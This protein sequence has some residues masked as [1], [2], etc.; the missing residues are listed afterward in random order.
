MRRR[1]TV[2]SLTHVS[3]IVRAY[4]KCLKDDSLAGEVLECSV[5]EILPLPMPELRN[6]RFSKRAV[7]VWDPLF[8][9]YHGEASELPDAIP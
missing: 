5:E 1:L 9:M 2:H 3:T 4:N 7:T 6:G 8:K